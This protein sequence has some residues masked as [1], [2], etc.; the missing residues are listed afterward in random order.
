MQLVLNTVYHIDRSPGNITY[1]VYEA[2]RNN[3]QMVKVAIPYA[4]GDTYKGYRIAGT[5]PELFGFNDDGTP[6]EGYNAQGRLLSGYQSPGIAEEDRDPNKKVAKD[7]FEYRVGRKFHIAQGRSF[8]AKKFEAVLGSD[9]PARTGLKIADKFKATHDIP[10]GAPSPEDE[11]DEQW[12]V[13]GVLEPTHTA[14]DRMI[15]IPLISFYAI[16]VHESAMEIEAAIKAG[17]DLS[18][19]NNKKKAATAPVTR[20]A[21]APAKKEEHDHDH[22]H[23]HDHKKE[24]AAPAAA[25]AKREGHDHD[26][27]H[28]HKHDHAKEGAA[29]AKKN[30]HD[31]DHD[32]AHDHAPKPATTRAATKPS[33]ADRAAAALAA[34][35]KDAHD[36]D[37]DHGH[38]DHKHEHKPATTSA[39]TKAAT[40]QAH[41]H[42]DHDHE[43][44]DDHAGHDHDDVYTLSADGTINL[45]LPKDKWMLSAVL[46]KTRAGF[47][48]QSMQYSFAKGVAAQAVNPA[49]VMREFFDTFLGP[50]TTVLLAISVL[51]MITAAVS[52]LVS[53]YNAVS[54]RSREIAIMRALGATRGK[55]LTLIC[56]EAGLI[57]LL[58]G[59]IG[60][61]AGHLIG[62][63][64]SR[65][66]AKKLGVGINWLAPG[67]EEWVYLAAVVVLATLAGLVPGLKAYRTPV[68]TNLVAA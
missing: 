19:L 24:G 35:A 28:D 5:S 36:H 18:Q 29:P 50:T 64:E 9:I 31:H 3:R 10:A 33:V 41:A 15:F 2:L 46:V 8:T 49:S 30:A 43:D 60:L 1:L 65:F 55:I 48:N 38:A 63:I 14:E 61:V 53:I 45:K 66:F 37:H 44:G 17:E 7:T 26:H 68:A 11:H 22:D 25:P 21:T 47:F 56:V 13:V 67:A 12:T 52:I 51:V 40:T 20:P 4:V 6:F 27:D 58:G 34:P 32:H 54:A 57:G 16:P 23:D 59:I 39:T 62:A 42:H